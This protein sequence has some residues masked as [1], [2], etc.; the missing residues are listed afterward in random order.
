MLDFHLIKALHS[1]AGPATLDV[2]LA[3]RPGEF[4][5]LYGP[6][7]AGK[8][9]LLRLLAGLTRPEAGYLR[10]GE[11][12]WYDDKRRVWLPPAHRSIGFVFQDYAL[13]PNMT[14]QQNL[15]FALPRQ[16]NQAIVPEL[17][18]LTGLEALAHRYPS[19][20][21]GGQQQRVALARALARRPRLLLLDEPLAAV[22]YPTRQHLQ[23]ALRHAHHEFNLTTIL[24]SHDPAEVHALAD[25]VIE[26]DLGRVRQDGP[27]TLLPTPTSISITQATIVKILPGNQARVRLASDGSTLLITLP[28][29]GYPYQPG[30]LLTLRPSAWEVCPPV[31]NKL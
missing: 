25:R 15:A 3:I 11:Q 9:T 17:L 29:D 4:V 2:H 19:Q 6:S 5:A 21:S 8:T 20:L 28:N 1:A 31:D 24:V 14:V 12:V 23:Q 18:T 26:L 16:Q 27:P 10:A 30:Q 22:D 13:F 7:G